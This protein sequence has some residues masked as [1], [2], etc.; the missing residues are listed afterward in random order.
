MSEPSRRD[1]TPT[2]SGVIGLIDRFISRPRRE[3]AGDDLQRLRFIVGAI[4][5]LLSLGL[6]RMAIHL[7]EGQLDELTEVAIAWSLVL[8]VALS[9]RAGISLVLAGHGLAALVT[10]VTMIRCLDTGGIES[11]SAFALPIV[12]V[13][14][15]LSMGWRAGWVWSASSLAGCVVLWR[16]GEP[17]ALASNDRVIS[18][19]LACLI[20]TGLA[21][22]FESLR[23]QALAALAE[24]RDRAQ[25]A[26][27]AKSR[28]LANMSHEIRTPMNGVLGMLGILLDTELKREQRDYAETAHASGVA[29]LDLINDVLDF[30]KIEAGQ[31][32]LEEV[33]FDLRTL[34]EEVLDQVSV[35]AA[36]KDL[37]LIAR[38]VPSTPTLVEGDHGRIRQILINLVGNAIKFTESGHVLVT[39]DRP[40]RPG[41]SPRFRFA[42]EDTGVGIPVEQHGEIFEHFHQVD[43]STAKAHAGTGLGLAIVRELVG[44]MRGQLD[45]HSTPG[46]GSTFTVYLPLELSDD[47][48]SESFIRPSLVSL[49][50][51][52]VDDHPV[53]RWVLREQLEH[54]HLRVLECASAEAALAQLRRAQAASEPFDLLL[55]DFHMPGMDGL[56][57]ARTVRDDP[58]LRLPVTVMLSSVTHRS[59]AQLM[60]EA[61]IRAYLVKP[62][63]HRRLL[64]V[65]G[66]AWRRRDAPSPRLIQRTGGHASSQP[67]VVSGLRVL[68]VEDN[69]VNQKVAQRML[70]GLGCRVDVAGDGREAIELWE[71]AAY[72]LVFMDLQMPV[73]DGLEA[74]VELRRREPAGARVPVVAMTA[75]VLATDRERCLAAGMDDYISKPVRRRD[76]VRVLE[77]FAPGATLAGRERGAAGAAGAARPSTGP[78]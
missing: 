16:V 30:S 27:E 2:S 9:I 69:A 37:E 1:T 62:V 43:M 28:F 64:E 17:A 21:F 61:G 12:P 60:E 34:V 74:T 47:P 32:V 59:S 71:V 46:K 22:V 72:D 48:P 24:A 19:V 42:V 65:L 8:A 15:I 51:L 58:E 45:L 52:V 13:I 73:M 36:R 56:E 50:A 39:V 5:L 38:Y 20:L 23:G 78:S 6:G 29:L 10:A 70:T 31:M 53:N 54:E 75:H 67:P 76:V 57:L 41:G 3:A 14:A 4:L 26:A 55:L 77:T 40:L 49:R 33:D 68:V 44:L 25:E 35:Q 7:G 11:P 66:E 18:M 63:H